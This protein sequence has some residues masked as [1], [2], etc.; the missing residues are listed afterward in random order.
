MVNWYKVI[1]RCLI[2]LIPDIALV[3]FHC[4]FLDVIDIQI[5]Y[6]LLSLALSKLSQACDPNQ[7][8]GLAHSL[9]MLL[10]E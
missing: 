2:P 1:A 4:E 7:E 5:G 9:L 3:H 8:R 10:R 6:R